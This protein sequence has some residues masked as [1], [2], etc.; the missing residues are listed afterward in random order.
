MLRGS[1][2]GALPQWQRLARTK[3]RLDNPVVR[4]RLVATSGDYRHW[5]EVQGRRLSRT[6]DPTRGAPLMKPPA[7]VTVLASHLRAGRRLG[8]RVD[9]ARP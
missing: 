6:M 4:L 8:D 9:G 1:R 2:T 5:V 3:A 7:S